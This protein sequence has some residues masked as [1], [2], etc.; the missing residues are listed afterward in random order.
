MLG[1]P[2]SAPKLVVSHRL[3][4]SDNVTKEKCLLKILV[5]YIVR[6]NFPCAGFASEQ[7]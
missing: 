1:F 2:L 4:L 6:Q 3:F 7:L 5:G